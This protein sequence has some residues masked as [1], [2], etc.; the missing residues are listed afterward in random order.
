M[1]V[2][3]IGTHFF[4]RYTCWAHWWTL[5]KAT[6]NSIFSIIIFHQH[7]F[8]N[9][10]Y[11][12]KTR[13]YLLGCIHSINKEVIWASLHLTCLINQVNKNE[14][15]LKV[16]L[17]MWMPLECR[18]YPDII[19]FHCSLKALSPKPWVWETHLNKFLKYSLLRRVSAWAL[20]FFSP[21]PLLF[22]HR[23][24]PHQGFISSNTIWFHI[25]DLHS[26]LIRLME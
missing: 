3:V 6:L 14:N 25:T 5:H 26:A 20:C 2:T 8:S 19:C 23:C 24:Q 9:P 10:I 22:Q 17:P 16:F 12:S 7:Q 4:L 11:V 13:H 18:N 1:G 21:V 15:S